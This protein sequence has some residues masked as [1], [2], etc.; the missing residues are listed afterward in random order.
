MFRKI[1][2]I[3]GPTATGK[4]ALAVKIAALHGGEIISADSRQIYKGMDIGVGK[5]QP[6]DTPIHLIDVVEPSV[7]FSVSNFQSLALRKIKTLHQQNILPIVV[8]CSG[9]YIDSIIS[10]KYTNF[11]TNQS[12]ILRF[13]LEKLPTSLLKYILRTVD[14]SSYQK[15]NNSDINN[16][17]RLVRKIELKLLASYSK[18][19]SPLPNNFDILHVTLTAPNEFLYPRIDTRVHQRLELGHLSELET[20]LSSYKW[21]DPGLEVSCYSVF[22]DY[23]DH[24]ISLNKAIELWKFAEH[25]DARHQKTWFKQYRNTKIIDVS[26]PKN[27]RKI[28]KTIGQW[29]NETIETSLRGTVATVTKQSH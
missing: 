21:S 1:L 24:K 10:Q 3:S 22:K 27:I 13:I 29:Y 26:D 18:K 6:I 16:P 15:L 20:L 11:G 17:R 25:K 28:I 2:I 19:V 9:L 12:P 7:R 8:G 23:L 14:I 5:D 4:T